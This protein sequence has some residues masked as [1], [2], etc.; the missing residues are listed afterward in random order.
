VI[1]HHPCG[2]HERV[3]DRRADEREAALLE[4]L[5]HRIGL[6][7]SGRHL[8]HG[9]PA[10]LPRRPADELPEPLDDVGV[11]G[12]RHERARVLNRSLDLQSIA[13]DARVRE[14]ALHACRRES[15]DARRVEAGKRRPIRRTFSKNR[16]PAEA[17]LCPLKYEHLEEARRHTDRDAPLVIVIGDIQEVATCP[18][19]P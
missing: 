4:R 6:G 19:A 12:E 15:R 3:A 8:F 2:L 1:V 7:R 9:S 11:V 10:V 17:C 18:R 13:D 5:A 14:Q 16:D